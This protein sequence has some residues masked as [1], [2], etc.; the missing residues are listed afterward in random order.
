MNK[1]LLASLLVVVASNAQAATLRCENGIA[2]R[3]DRTSEVLRKCGTPVS[4]SVTGYV[5]DNNG[6]HKFV[7]E[8]WVY[9]PRSGMIY[10]L[11]F[12][13]ERLVRVNSKRSD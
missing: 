10:F 13:G 8:E 7:K 12:E 3:G 11:Q 4:Q 1:L 9:G 2:D 5:L 6:N